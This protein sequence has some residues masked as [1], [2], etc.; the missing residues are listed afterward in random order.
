MGFCRCYLATDFYPRPPRGGRPA[1][2]AEATSWRTDFYPRPPRGGRRSQHRPVP[3]PSR[4]LSTPSARR[5]TVTRH[6][7]AAWTTY[8]YPRPPRGGRLPAV[9]ALLCVA[10]IS[11][12]ALREEG[13]VFPEQ[14]V[15]HEEISIHALREEGDAVQ[16]YWC[17]SA[18]RFLSTPSAR[19]ATLWYNPI[20]ERG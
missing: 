6:T 10:P 11:I 19:R 2:N 12:H 15:R 16:I 5:A 8:F 18:H 1:R 9:E 13:D 17:I 3:T 4:F 7:N 20:K 14:P